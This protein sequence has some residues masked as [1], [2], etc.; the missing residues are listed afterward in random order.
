MKPDDLVIGID[1]SKQYLDVAFG[2][3]DKATVRLEYTEQKV[4]ELVQHCQQ[5]S[6]SLIVLESTGGL[7]RPL[8]TA[9]LQA[10][11]PV[12]RIQPQRIRYF[13]KSLGILAKTDR[14][15]AQVLVRYGETARPQPTALPT[16]QQQQLA[17]L[18]A[19]RQQLIEMRVS[20]ENRLS[21]MPKDVQTNI[22]EHL[23]YLHTAIEQIETEI[24]ELIADAPDMREKRDLMVA[25]PGVGP[26]TT[27]VLLARLPE[28]GQLNRKQI[29]ALVG[30]APFNKDS[31]GKSGKR[32]IYGG[33]KDVRQALYMATLSATRFN[34]VIKAFYRR[35]IDAGKPF[36]V[37]LV[38]AMRKLL[39]ILNAILRS[40]QPWKQPAHQTSP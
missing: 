23:D 38:A 19:R 34:P 28:L 20:E 26:V 4:R 37:A 30:L 9:M 11:L 22:Q 7:E 32:T 5:Q 31:G 21:T 27:S 39:T 33:R 25:V 13:A 1:V 16:E 18:V 14:L 29:V 3:Q 12:A 10:G 40:R 6:P 15:D 8:M 35:L 2:S 36:K 17:G 24:D